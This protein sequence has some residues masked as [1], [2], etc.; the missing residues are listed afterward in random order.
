[1]VFSG[2]PDMFI[3]VNDILIIYIYEERTL[4]LT[5]HRKC[6]KATYSLCLFFSALRL[7]LILMVRF[8]FYNCMHKYRR[9]TIMVD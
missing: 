5:F 6:F 4:K 7:R 9:R 2:V 8:L 1:M 3:M